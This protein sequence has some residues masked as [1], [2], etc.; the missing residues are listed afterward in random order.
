MKI[1]IV[2]V[3]R[4]RP[5]IPMHRTETDAWVATVQYRQRGKKLQARYHFIPSVEKVEP[6]IRMRVRPEWLK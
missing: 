2:E 3:K 4:I 6:G 1:R 5:L